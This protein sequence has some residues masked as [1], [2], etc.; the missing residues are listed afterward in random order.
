MIR[1]I[2]IAILRGIFIGLIIPGAYPAFSNQ[3]HF[4]SAT[5]YEGDIAVMIV[6]YEN[7]QPSLFLLDTTVLQSDFEVLRVDSSVG[8]EVVDNRLVNTMRWLVHLHPLK[9]GLIDTPALDIRGYKTPSLRLKVNKISLSE[10]DKPQVRVE[11]STDRKSY[12][13][14]QQIKVTMRLIYNR[15]I[16]EG[17]FGEPKV[18]D[19]RRYR[20]GRER[21]Y[22]QEV[23]GE[24]F[25]V[26]ERQLVLVT[27]KSGL[28]VVPPV[29][30]KGLIETD[31]GVGDNQERRLLRRSAP[32]DLVVNLPDVSRTADY[33]IPASEV[34]A[35]QTWDNL[36]SDLTIGASVIRRLSLVVKSVPA[37]NLPTNLFSAIDSTLDIYSD[38]ESIRNEFEQADIVGRLDQD[39]V[40]VLAKSGEVQI[41]DIKIVWWNVLTN[42]E[43]ITILP[44]I[45]LNVKALVNKVSKLE[46]SNNQSLILEWHNWQQ[47]NAGLL[48]SLLIVFSLSLKFSTQLYLQIAIPAFSW[49]RLFQ[50]CR[51]NNS[52]MTKQQILL[53][54]VSRWP[55]LPYPG[56]LAISGHKLS[57]DFSNSLMELDACLYQKSPT[58]WNGIHL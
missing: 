32:I 42:K 36:E 2:F 13:P 6:E 53:W 19:F 56:L 22:Q 30:F 21:R 15:P 24:K 52:G 9:S 38:R 43:E 26:I 34:R 27:E 25:D 31:N 39:Y 46:K 8:R 5:I 54:A 41:P 35:A 58:P 28:L 40:I 55:D 18:D 23:N 49:W 3:A 11:A 4:E 48:I 44:G 16:V 57:A 17:D 50:A 20:S 10:I 14:G 1:N 12:F 7:D 29:E 33:W 45:T 37:E 47:I 51:Q